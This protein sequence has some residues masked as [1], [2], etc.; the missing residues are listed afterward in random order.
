[1]S[2]RGVPQ[3]C[4]DGF[5]ELRAGNSVKGVGKG[6]SPTES[7]RSAPLGSTFLVAKTGSGFTSSDP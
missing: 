6:L 3:A 7:C 2:L 1:M 5:Q 4:R